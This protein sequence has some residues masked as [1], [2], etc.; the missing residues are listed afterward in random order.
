MALS[1]Q[2]V[3]EAA[4]V[5]FFVGLAGVVAFREAVIIAPSSSSELVATAGTSHIAALL[6]ATV[7]VIATAI[8]LVSVIRAK[9]SR[10]ASRWALGIGAFAITA[11]VLSGVVTSAWTWLVLEVLP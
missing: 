4:I 7:A 1:Q 6:F 2:R 5:A 10:L 11:I 8:L 3:Q 9:P